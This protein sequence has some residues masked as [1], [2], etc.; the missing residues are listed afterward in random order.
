MDTN[1]RTTRATGEPSH[2]GLPYE[3]PVGKAEGREKTVAVKGQPAPPS[4]VGEVTPTDPAG[5][6]AAEQ[7]LADTDTDIAT[8]P[9]SK[10]DEM[11]LQNIREDL[12]QTPTQNVE[13]KLIHQ[14][15]VT[16][17]SQAIDIPPSNI[18]RVPQPDPPMKPSPVQAA[19]RMKQS[20]FAGT[21]R[22]SSPGKTQTNPFD[23]D[24][25]GISQIYHDE[26]AAAVNAPVRDIELK[27]KTHIDLNENKENNPLYDEIL[28]V[29]TEPDTETGSRQTE[30]GSRQTETGSHQTETRSN[31]DTMVDNPLRRPFREL[32][33]SER[34]SPDSDTSTASHERPIRIGRTVQTQEDY[35]ANSEMIQAIREFVTK[36]STSTSLTVGDFRRQIAAVES[37][38]AE[39]THTIRGL[40]RK[41]DDDSQLG[42]EVKRQRLQLHNLNLRIDQ[43]HAHTQSAEDQLYAVRKDHKNTVSELEERISNLERIRQTAPAP[44]QSVSFMEP[45]RWNVPQYQQP[46]LAP[47]REVHEMEYDFDIPVEGDVSR[48]QVDGYADSDDPTIHLTAWSRLTKEISQIAYNAQ[49]QEVTIPDTLGSYIQSQRD[50]D[51]LVDMVTGTIVAVRDIL[52][53]IDMMVEIQLDAHKLLLTQAR[54]LAKLGRVLMNKK[55]LRDENVDVSA[56]SD[57]IL[58]I[59]NLSTKERAVWIQVSTEVEL[60]VRKVLEIRNELLLNFGKPVGTLKDT[61]GKY[62]ISIAAAQILTLLIRRRMIH[63]GFVVRNFDEEMLDIQ[64]Y[65]AATQT[66]PKLLPMDADLNDQ[67]WF[68]DPLSGKDNYPHASDTGLT[69]HQRPPPSITPQVVHVTGAQFPLTNPIP[70]NTTPRMTYPLPSN[71]LPS[72]PLPS[73]PLPSNPPPIN[74]TFTGLTHT[75]S[76][77]FASNPLNPPQSNPRAPGPQM[78]R[79]DYAV[80]YLSNRVPKFKGADWKYLRT[81]VLTLER[82][83]QSYNVT[84]D[85]YIL[86]LLMNTL[87]PETQAEVYSHISPPRLEYISVSE[88]LQTMEGVYCRTQDQARSALKNPRPLHKD[89]WGK[90]LAR[91]SALVSDAFPYMSRT[92]KDS[93]LL[94][95]LFDLIPDADVRRAVSSDHH[96]RMNPTDFIRLIQHE[97]TTKRTQ[98]RRDRRKFVNSL[99]PDNTTDDCILAVEI[100]EDDEEEDVNALRKPVPGRKPRR[101]PRKDK[102]AP[103][104]E[105]KVASVGSDKFGKER[106]KNTKEMFEKYRSTIK[107]K[108]AAHRKTVTERDGVCHSC[109][110]KGHWKL[111]CPTLHDPQQ[112]VYTMDQVRDAIA[113]VQSLVVDEEEADD[114]VLDFY[115]VPEGGDESDWDPEN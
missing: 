40:K 1:K 62:G 80:T 44:A 45:A 26:P 19:V 23:D 96:K 101:P 74:P 29:K 113:C 95:Y 61:A 98:L 8:E 22:T 64:R 31:T 88:F 114:M 76:A 71:P 63:G 111:E 65:R 7:P 56:T 35:T 37:S 68:N 27:F 20:L 38:L 87:E 90:A 106:K 9:L 17:K 73:N 14:I 49:P 12:R 67:A 75:P 82:N 18:S 55:E 4:T 33:Y 86:K 94:D 25:M 10:L 115:E 16:T 105:S 13:E 52:K 60:P 3:G 100:Q 57:L 93:I 36:E 83:L 24:L 84:G 41:A 104:T 39:L 79:N 102:P 81:H 28:R 48:G 109:G 107:P 15:D 43:L 42:A 11:I 99:N 69:P 58:K 78:D 53:V 112:N 34:Q 77:T 47:P 103:K 21:V 89:T 85:K 59:I 30:T 92:E 97:E 51:P 46:D 54:E 6:G 91:G 110:E 108:I 72:N 66:Q 2:S 50:S 32:S 70:H 5:E